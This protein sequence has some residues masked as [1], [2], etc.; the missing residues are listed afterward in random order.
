MTISRALF[1]SRSSEWET[2]RALFDE[3]NREFRFTLDAA[4]S[5][6]NA[7]CQRYYTAADDALIQSWGG[8]SVFCNPPY[9][10]GVI[11]WAQKAYQE[12]LKPNTTV[13]LLVAARTDARFFH[14]FIYRKSEIRFIRGRLHFEL[15]GIPQGRAP[16]PSLLAIYT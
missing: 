9:G 7:K 3:L 11:R 8:E 12:S 2:P 1:S 15:N 14:E 10:R 6:L 16:F 13:V 5:D 4:A